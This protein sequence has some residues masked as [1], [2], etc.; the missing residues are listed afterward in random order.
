MNIYP[1]IYTKVPPEISPWDKQGFHTVFYPISLLDRS[2]I[3]NLEAHIHVPDIKNFEHKQTV[4]FQHLE[5]KD[6]LV[7]IDIRALREARDEYGRAGIVLAQGFL[8]PPL[9]WQMVPSPLMLLSLIKEAIFTDIDSLLKSPRFN[10]TTGD[11]TPLDISPENAKDWS[12]LPPL[13]DSFELRLAI[14][15]NRWAQSTEPPFS[16]LIEGESEQVGDLLNKVMAYVPNALKSRIGWDPALDDGRLNYF[17]LHIAGYSEHPAQGGNPLRIKLSSRTIEGQQELAGFFR[18]PSPY[19]LW[20]E[21]CSREATSVDRRE[22]AY[23]LSD[24]LINS[25]PP[26]PVGDLKSLDCFISANAESIN[27]SFA[28]GCEVK[29]GKSLGRYLSDA[30]TE[31]NKLDMLIEDLP[32]QKFVKLVENAVLEHELKSDDVN[33]S[34]LASI[35]SSGSNLLR[36]LQRVWEGGT[37]Q[38]EELGSIPAKIRI[39]FVQYLFA[40]T[41]PQTKPQTWLT[42]LLQQDEH[43][44]DACRSSPRIAPVIQTL[45]AD[46]LTSNNGLSTIASQLSEEAF[47]RGVGY[48]ALQGQVDAISLL[49]SLIKQNRLNPKEIKWL[50]E[51]ARSRQCPEQCP[52]YVQAFLYPGMGIPKQVWKD[53]ELVR[54]LLECLI[55]FHHKSTEDVIVLGFSE[56]MVGQYVQSEKQR[57]GFWAKIKNLVGKDYGNK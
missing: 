53:A 4:F 16:I 34:G 43:I 56:E 38:P 8:F 32:P 9:L 36:L 49:D 47:A 44:F 26:V 7:I 46:E 13:I 35:I 1:F 14:L 39:K 51:W 40:T 30:V 24:F 45:V 54:R 25:E 23:G 12:S 28:Q 57:N 18:S 55:V 6:Y 41:K 21:H 17:P 19:D 5:D 10:K 27:Q 37:I 3:A 11:V 20:L 42:A 29:F 50:V 33:Q 48:A 22:L 2:D 31:S 52:P 15:L